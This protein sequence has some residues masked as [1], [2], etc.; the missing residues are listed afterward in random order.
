M[1]HFSK[2][3]RLDPHIIFEVSKQIVTARVCCPEISMFERHEHAVL[4]TCGSRKDLVCERDTIEITVR[5]IN[6]GEDDHMESIIY[7][8]AVQNR[9]LAW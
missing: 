7:I 6:R 1:K 8:C 4:L 2:M 5:K 3:A 9:D